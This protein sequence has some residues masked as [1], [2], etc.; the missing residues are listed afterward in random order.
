MKRHYWFLASRPGR[1]NYFN[2]PGTEVYCNARIRAV[3][4]IM[5]RKWFGREPTEHWHKDGS[6]A[7]CWDERGNRMEITQVNY[8]EPRQW[9]HGL[10]TPPSHQL[11]YG[12]WR[13]A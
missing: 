3:A 10:I 8:G 7:E 5:F 9:R 4:I 13:A 2:W 11:T 12:N 1:A 6:M